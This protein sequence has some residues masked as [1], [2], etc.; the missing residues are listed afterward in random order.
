MTKGVRNIS[1]LGDGGWGTTLAIYLIRKNYHVQLWGAFPDYI[2]KIKRT[3]INYKFLPGITIPKEV[4]LTSDLKIAISKAQLIILA[5]PSQYAR[6]ILKRLRVYDLSKKIFMSVIKGIDNTTLLRM[7]QIIYKELGSVRLAV[8][9][10]PNIAR[11]IAR[12]VP[13]T[14]VVAS[15]DRSITKKLQ[16]I[17]NSEKF[18]IYTNADVIG[19][20]LGGSLKNVIAIACGVCDGLGYGANTK[21]A[22]LTRGLAEIARLGKALGAKNQTFSGL[23]G[24]GDLVT[25]CFSSQSRNR[26]VG[27][28]LGK[29]KTIQQITSSMD[30]IAEGIATVKA[31]YK[32]SQKYHVPMPITREVYNI[33]YKDK[34]PLKAVMGLM[35]RKMKAE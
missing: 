16:A 7:S 14:A 30:M 20:E 35:K 28:E 22:I 19:V 12:G 23:S 4:E 8:L 34:R 11:E 26:Y 3:R 24:L 5:I 18:R 2:E 9:S 13:S 27:E 15:H 21:A 29:G 17:L 31:A 6:P 33:I 1:I 25:T 32:L 10:G